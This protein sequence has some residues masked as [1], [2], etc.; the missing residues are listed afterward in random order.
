MTSF[1]RNVDVHVGAPE[2]A[3]EDALEVAEHLD[4]VEQDVV[5]PVV[6]EPGVDVPVE[7]VRVPVGGVPPV[8]EG[9]LED[10]PVVHAA[11]AEV[12]PELPED[13]E[14]LP[15]APD[16]GDDLDEAVPLSVDELA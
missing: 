3:V 9:H 4:L 1:E 14:G 16:P 11:L 2:Q 8:V 10:V 13:E 5:G 7:G 6:P 15:A 12:V